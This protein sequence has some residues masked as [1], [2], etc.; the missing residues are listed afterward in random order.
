MI[1]RVPDELSKDSSKATE[2]HS[3]A[4]DA[5]GSVSPESSFAVAS[6]ASAEGEKPKASTAD[7]IKFVGLLVFVALLVLIGFL[8]APYIDY[9]TTT[10]GR[11]EL[12]D[13]IRG[14]HAWGVLICLGLQFLQIVV[15]FIPGEVVQL[16]IGAIYGPL[17]GTLVIAFGALISSIFVFFVVHKLGAPFVH[18]MIS[19]KHADKLAFLQDGRRLNIIVF[20]LFLIPGL[21]KDIFTYLIPLTNMRAVNFFVLSTLGRLPGIAASAYIGN[22]A[23]QGNYTEAIV[24]SIIAGALGLAGIIFNGKIMNL[25]DTIMA[26]LHRH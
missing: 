15:A 5:A 11:S 26:K 21:P 19:K 20:V 7:K 17:W 8:L 10:D 22:A 3:D 12:V 18:A 23:V 13:M 14:Q 25:V 2:H 6:A 16:V 9:L 4:S 1:Q 24:V